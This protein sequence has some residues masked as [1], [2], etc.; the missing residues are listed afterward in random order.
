MTYYQLSNINTKIYEH[1]LKLKFTNKGDNPIQISKSLSKY[2]FRTKESITNHAEEWDAVKKLTNPYEFIHTPISSKSSAISKIKPLSRAF[3]KL[4]EMCNVLDLF[5]PFKLEPIKSFHLAEGPGGFIEAMTY[6]RFNL[7]DE[8][9]GM[10]LIDNSNT[11]IPGWKKS[12]LFLEKNKNV[13]I[14]NGIDKTGNLYHP[15]NFKYCI[16]KYGNS[17]NF[18]TGDGGFDFSVD[19][20]RQESLAL[21]LI[22][23]QVAYALGMQAKGGSFVLKIFDLFSKAS[24]DILYIL[25]AFYKHTYIIKPHTSRIANSEKY[26]V[27]CGF[28]YNDTSAISNK[29]LSIL[30]VLNNM[31]LKDIL[32]SRLLNIKIN[33]QFMITI[34]E[35]NAIIGQQQIANILSTLRIIQNKERKGEKTQTLKNKNIQKCINW[36]VKNKI[37]HHRYGISTN[38]FLSPVA[39]F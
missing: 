5:K 30:Y 24:I 14:E 39:R 26:I 20:N 18:I 3:F 1:N 27:C 7:K 29:F 25:A 8:Y 28:K 15:E 38:I 21:R 32:I 35:I 33:Y 4:V 11:N 23:T 34:E 2:L 13:I 12:E 37:P 6:L 31:Q 16:E 17:M 10:T 36:C 19:Y 9:Y 22:L